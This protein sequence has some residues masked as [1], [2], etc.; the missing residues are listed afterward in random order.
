MDVRVLL[1]C[2]NLHGMNDNDFYQCPDTYELND[3]TWLERG[4]H[5]RGSEFFVIR[6]ERLVGKMHDYSICSKHFETILWRTNSSFP[7]RKRK[8]HDPS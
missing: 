7:S 6:T 5:Y 2:S 4:A 1:A 8:Y 3:D